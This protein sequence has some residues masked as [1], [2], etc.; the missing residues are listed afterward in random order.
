[1]HKKLEWGLSL[2]RSRGDQSCLRWS[3]WSLV[4]FVI[5]SFYMKNI[6]IPCLTDKFDLKSKNTYFPYVGKLPSNSLCTLDFYMV[7]T[8]VILINA[9]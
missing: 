4:L 9:T 1:M 3:K 8:T 5:L 7:N 2:G 6:F